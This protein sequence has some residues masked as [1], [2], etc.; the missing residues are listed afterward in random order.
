MLRPTRAFARVGLGGMVA[1]IVLGILGMHTL[2]PPPDGHA[3]TMAAGAIAPGDEDHAGMVMNLPANEQLSA[4]VPET[5]DHENHSNHGLGHLLML[6]TALLAAAAAAV[7]R[8][9][10]LVARHRSTGVLAAMRSGASPHFVSRP[11]TGPPYVWS[12][13]VIRC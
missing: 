10:L 3:M 13:S 6:C 4:A 2:I 12:F 8:Y 7:V 11:G 5:L 1:G 9:L